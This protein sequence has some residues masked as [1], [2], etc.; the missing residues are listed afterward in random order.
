MRYLIIGLGIFGAN[1]AKDLTNMGHEV[2]GADRSASLV[3]AVKEQISAAYIVDST[4]EAGLSALPVKGVDLVIV[5][6]GENFAA[7]IRTVALLKKA[8]VKHIYARAADELHRTILQGLQIDRIIAP[9]QRA[10]RDLSLELAFGHQVESLS[11][12][13]DLYAVKLVLPPALE[14]IDYVQLREQLHHDFAITLIAATRPQSKRNLLGLPSTYMVELDLSTSVATAAD[15]L[16]IYGSKR[17]IK[18]LAA[19]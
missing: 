14:G 4:D 5:A 12:T 9:E 2:I 8:G 10:A 13:P 15:T 7:S 16:L 3:E 1:L 17:A 11:L 18:R 19:S 6:I